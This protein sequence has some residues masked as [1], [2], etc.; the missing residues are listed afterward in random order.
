MLLNHF[1]T[2]ISYY[3]GKQCTGSALFDRMKQEGPEALKSGV[4]SYVIAWMLKTRSMTPSLIYKVSF[5]LRKIIQISVC[6][7]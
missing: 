5:S 3:S 2:H 1:N 7:N 6:Q 4:T